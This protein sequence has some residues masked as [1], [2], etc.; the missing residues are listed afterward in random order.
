M[1]IDPGSTLATAYNLGN[2]SL[3]LPASQVGSFL[4]NS[5]GGS[6][7][8]DYYKFQISSTT[9]VSFSLSNLSGDVD[10]LLQDSTGKTV[11][12]SENSGTATETIN[13]TLQD[14]STYYLRVQSDG[15]STNYD[16]AIGGESREL[17]AVPFNADLGRF[18]NDRTQWVR[19]IT[20]GTGAYHRYKIQ[21]SETSNLN[22]SALG[23]ERLKLLNGSGALIATSSAYSLELN[24][25]FPNSDFEFVTGSTL[26]RVVGAGTY[27]VEVDSINFRID[28]PLAVGI[29]VAAVGSAT[30]LMNAEFNAGDL[31]SGSIF[32]KTDVVNNNDTSDI[33]KFTLTSPRN[34]NVALIGLTGN[35]DIRL[36]QNVSQNG[37]IEPSEVLYSS[38]RQGNGNESLNIGSL[39]AGTY[40][41]QVFHVSSN[42]NYK[43][44]MSTKS[45]TIG[46]DSRSD[47]LPIEVSVG[48]LST[49]Y[50]ASNVITS[51]NTT[52]TYRFS[53]GG[54]RT[55]Q[56]SL[57]SNLKQ[58]SLRIVKDNNNN[59]TIDSS[60][61][62]YQSLGVNPNI[63]NPLS[64]GTYFVVIDQFQSGP[65]DYDLNLKVV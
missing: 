7:L 4:R 33:Y 62:V 51:K 2:M 5:L 38:R 9:N 20:F 47:L 1:P 37:V 14:G 43:L 30:P 29:S 10:L 44:L 60:D 50:K 8:V 11:A 6:D 41:L 64:A 61:L 52:D 65:V 63:V 15:T 17:L 54:S 27:F 40:F 34:L 23:T 3:A 48:T 39:A 53:L 59:G 25:I 19:G 42:A 58:L 35:A 12:I 28:R 22:L 24:T 55:V 32:S 26:S 13:A 57:E 18:D 16:L 56:A 36:F 46:L 21:I 49:S 31:T 45:P